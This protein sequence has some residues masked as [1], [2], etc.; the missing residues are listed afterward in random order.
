[1]MVFDAVSSEL[2]QYSSWVITNSIEPAAAGS[3]F[4]TGQNWVGKEIFNFTAKSYVAITGLTF[5]LVNWALS[6]N[7]TS[8][9]KLQGS[10]DGGIWTDLSTPVAST[11][12]S[13]TFTVNNT[14]APTT[15]FKYFRL[16][17]VAGTSSYGGVTYV[18]MN[19]V[20][21]YNPSANPKE[22]C[23][24]IDSDNDGKFNHLDLD[25]D[26][27]LCFDAIEAGV[28]TSSVDGMLPSPWGT[29][30][31]ADAKETVADN[32]IYNSQ[33]TYDY[34]ITKGL[35]VCADF[36]GDGISDINDLDDD[37]DGILDQ[38][39]SPSC[40]NTMAEMIKPI[41]V[42]SQLGQHSTNLIE[43]AID[44]NPVTKSA[45]LQNLDWVGKE[46]FKLEAAS[47]TLVTGL[48]FDMD[49]WAFA[50]AASSTFKLQ[51]S[52]D[53]YIWSDLSAPM[54][55]QATTGTVTIN[56][57][58]LPTIKFKYLRIVGVAGI[59]SYVGVEDLRINIPAAYVSGANPKATCIADRDNDLRLNHQDLD[60][61]GDGCFD[62]VEA[63]VLPRTTT[64]GIVPGTSFG[65]NGFANDLET[66]ADNGIY[67]S[68]YNYDYA[69]N[70]TII[71]CTDTD[72]DG[73]LNLI[74]IDD[75]N[76]GVLD[77]D[78]APTC[79]ISAVQWNTTN[80]TP[81][82]T[83][84]SPLN[85]LAPNTNFA[86]LTDNATTAA[87][88]FVTATAQSQYNRELIRATFTSPVQLDAI[89][90]AKTSSTQIFSA[91]ASSL[92]LQGTNDPN[93]SWINLLA[94]PI[95]SPANATNITANGSVSLVNS[96]KFTI[97]TNAGRYKHY[98]IFGLTDSD[99]LT[100]VATEFYFDVN[101]ATYI[102][103]TFTNATC[104]TDTDADGIINTLD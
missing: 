60:S 1:M 32:G 39:E 69:V 104:T 19:L 43:Y 21:P 86:A 102:P 28:L 89:Y 35:N 70:S 48:S 98:R 65:V 36:D 37:N 83:I 30:G 5:N 34:A 44:N 85:T 41:S 10:V 23:V 49:S 75:D 61:D 7:A 99:V 3:A 31:L 42:S 15:K 73:L 40:F 59:S 8:T 57:T 17:G 58:L 80:K 38:I 29:N 4:N 84:S 62:A 13:G 11:A 76:D 27:D 52:A 18:A 96:N 67:K 14:L 2:T 72:G 71:N 93:G 22:T 54:S 94:A 79:Y 12:T 87:V 63:G 100:G 91:T 56:N 78:E 97:A 95:A 24:G 64:T 53:N 50:A 45:F 55:S 68:L 47:Y 88:Q 20:A 26:G 9:F 103:S 77:A 51:G 90:I 16:I 92:M 66:L 25:S 82:V 81:F 74:D 46:I 6:A 33:Y 101:A